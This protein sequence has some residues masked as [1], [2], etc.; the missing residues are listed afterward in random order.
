MIQKYTVRTIFNAVRRDGG[1]G[2]RVGRGE[3][4]EC[5]LNGL[6]ALGEPLLVALVLVSMEMAVA[7]GAPS[8]NFSH[9][10]S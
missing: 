7:R 3:R 9:M 1:F 8:A 5:H 4:G 10:R 6:A 2:A